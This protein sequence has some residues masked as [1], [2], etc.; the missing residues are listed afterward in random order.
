MPGKEA[1][2]SPLQDE[3]LEVNVI[4]TTLT[5]LVNHSSVH[6]RIFAKYTKEP[7]QLST[8]AR[9][10]NTKRLH[11]DNYYEKKDTENPVSIRKAAR[12]FG[13][14]YHRLRRRVHELPSRSNRHP[15]NLKFTEAQYDSLFDDPDSLNRTG[16]PLTAKR[17]RD[18]AEA[19]LQRSQPDPALSPPKL[20]K[21]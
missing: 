10:T 21:M 5:Y 17:I 20:S 2:K 1:Y 6:H 13:L 14:S 9:K 4:L 16:V 3:T 12:E 7:C 11:T 8:R 15:A 18:A 19:I